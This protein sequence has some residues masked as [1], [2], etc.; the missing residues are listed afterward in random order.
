VWEGV[1]GIHGPG[2]GSVLGMQERL[3]LG[4][5]PWR[6]ASLGG[7]GQD[8]G[9]PFAWNRTP[10]GPCA[11]PSTLPRSQGP[12]APGPLWQKLCAPKL[13]TGPARHRACNPEKL[14]PNFICLARRQAD[15]GQKGR[16]PLSRTRSRISGTSAPR[17]ILHSHSHSSHH[18]ISHRLSHLP[19]VSGPCSLPAPAPRF[20]P[21]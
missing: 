20:P 13:E 12:S 17:N 15:D 16:G 11:H 10:A 3:V 14:C 19:S 5:G 4:A 6:R 9:Y 21:R 2:H 1:V 8:R 7:P 18:P